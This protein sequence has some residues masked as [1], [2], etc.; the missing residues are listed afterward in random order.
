MTNKWEIVHRFE[1]SNDVVQ[2][3]RGSAEGHIVSYIS[4]FLQDDVWGFIRAGVIGIYHV[5]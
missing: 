3:I 5:Q 4:R 1:I 2:S